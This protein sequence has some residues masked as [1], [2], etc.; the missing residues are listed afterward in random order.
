MALSPSRVMGVGTA[1]LLVAMGGY[2]VLDGQ[3]PVDAFYCACITLSTVGY[4]DICPATKS[5]EMKMFTVSLALLAL[6]FFC[7]PVMDLTSSW[8]D[9]LH[10]QGAVGWQYRLGVA[11]VLLVTLATGAVL[12]TTIEG[13]PV[14][15]ALY[16]SMITGTTIG[17]GDHPE[18]KTDAG[19]IAAAI[20]A[21]ASVNVIGF[22]T[23]V[24]GE[25][26]TE[27]VSEPDTEG[28]GKDQ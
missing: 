9:F 24:I 17:F 11:S 14:S 2:I 3:R 6:G 28:A 5:P 21:L 1:I 13:W 4:G 23:S 7:G 15:E 20:F 19:K 18:F 16:F 26:L 10:N 22:V 25:A 8:K 27:A 12:F